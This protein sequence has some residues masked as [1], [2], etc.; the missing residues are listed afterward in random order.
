M[1]KAIFWDND[2]VLVDTEKLYYRAN[3]EIFA[4]MGIDLTKELYIEFFL[5]KALG[6]WH[7]AEAKGYSK[8]QIDSYHVERDELYSFLLST[9]MSVIK[10]AEETLHKL[11]GKFK[12]GIVTSSK[13]NHFELIHKRS[14]LLKYFDFV[15]ASGDYAKSKPAPDPYLKA[16]ELSGFTKEECVAVED[17]ERGLLAAKNAGIRCYVIPT[18][19]T[20]YSNFNSAD[21]ILG[22]ISELPDLLI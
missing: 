18:E 4:K 9:E 14:D 5:K 17:S 8:G 19:L 22:N 3:K 20:K 2:G 10:G 6:T 11:C 16:V 7:I 12:M 21:K 13:R 15:L 1:I